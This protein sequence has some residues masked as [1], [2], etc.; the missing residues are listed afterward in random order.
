MKQSSQDR[1]NIE[2]IRGAAL[3]LLAALALAWCLVGLNL[4]VPALKAIFAGKQIRLVQAHIDFLLMTALI[5]GIYAAK[6]P[7]HWTLRWSMVLG[8]FGN[9]SLFLLQAIFPAFDAPAP[10]DGQFALAF[11]IYTFASVTMT[12]YGF[13]G[14]AISILRWTFRSAPASSV[15]GGRPS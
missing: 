11:R 6:A 2:L 4:G 5:L 12:T 1:L 7:L 8:A 15:I 10:A 3:W 14:A 13:G 9:S